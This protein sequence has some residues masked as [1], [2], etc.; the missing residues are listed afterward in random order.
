MLL[1][2]EEITPVAKEWLLWKNK[3]KAENGKILLLS[4][5]NMF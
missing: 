4:K 2:Y 1:C 5:Q 3:S